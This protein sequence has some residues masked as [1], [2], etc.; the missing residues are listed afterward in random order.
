MTCS[1][2][3]CNK[4]AKG[5]GLCPMHLQRLQRYGSV[6]GKKEKVER[7]CSVAGCERKHYAGGY[8]EMHR[9]Q[10]RKRGTIDDISVDD[11]LGEEWA[12]I[13]GR[14]G[15]MIS[16]LGRVKSIRKRHEKLLTPRLSKA[17]GTA[18]GGTV[19]VSDNQ[20]G[21]DINVAME[22]LR[23]F[24]PNIHGDFK[25]H[26]K[27]GDRTNCCADNL[28]W[29]GYDVLIEK[30]IAA[31]EASDSKWADCFLKYW[32]GDKAALDEFF[33]EMRTRLQRWL[34]RRL[35]RMGVSWYADIEDHVQNALVNA[36]M[37]IKRGMVTDFEHITG[38]VFKIAENIVNWW[39]RYAAPLKLDTILNKD[40]EEYHMA[41][42]IGFCHPSAEM[43]AIF[44]EEC[45]A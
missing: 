32:H 23:A 40:G 22:V 20:A 1:V 16:T 7:K 30:A 2:D 41:D 25:P 39:V 9:S 15:V 33:V 19:L 35:E 17:D 36:F 6:D 4:P 28:A 42:M 8:C 24:H 26:F 29:Y 21:K 45:G 10:L 18:L 31:A 11:L 14:N 37:A 38:W 3:G 13:D 12:P 34:P 5:H 27:D 44:N 43:T